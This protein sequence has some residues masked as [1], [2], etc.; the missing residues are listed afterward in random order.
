MTIAQVVS[1]VLMVNVL[2]VL[3]VRCVPMMLNRHNCAKSVNMVLSQHMINLGVLS[4][5]YKSI[6]KVVNVKIAQMNSL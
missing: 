6:Y 5:G 1:K 3:V 4:V 2:N